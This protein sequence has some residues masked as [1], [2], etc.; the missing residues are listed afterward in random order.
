MRLVR[1]SSSLMRITLATVFT[2]HRTQVV[3]LPTE[4]RLPDDVKTL[5]VRIRGKDRIITP[6]V[7]SWDHFFLSG[8]SVTEDFMNNR[9]AQK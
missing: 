3:R 6:I 9:G 7:K 2:S 8:P 4:A 5:A 1:N